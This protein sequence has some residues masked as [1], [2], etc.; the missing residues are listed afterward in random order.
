[1]AINWVCWTH[2]RELICEH[3]RHS[4]LYPKVKLLADMSQVMEARQVIFKKYAKMI[5]HGISLKFDIWV[6]DMSLI[7]F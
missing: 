7:C 5:T 4:L 6:K 2:W 3:R 1:M